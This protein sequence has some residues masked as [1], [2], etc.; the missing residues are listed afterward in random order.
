MLITITNRLIYVVY[1]LSI[2]KT[3]LRKGI[4]LFAKTN[5]TNKVYKPSNQDVQDETADPSSLESWKFSSSCGLAT[6]QL[7]S[8]IQTTQ[9]RPIG[10]K[11]S[12]IYAIQ[13]LFWS[14]NNL[15][16]FLRH[17]FTG[18]T[19]CGTRATWLVPLNYQITW[20]SSSMYLFFLHLLILIVFFRILFLILSEL[21][22]IF[23]SYFQIQLWSRRISKNQ[24]I[25]GIRRLNNNRKCVVAVCQVKIYVFAYSHIFLALS[26]N[27]IHIAVQDLTWVPCW[28]L[29]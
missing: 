8:K 4:S 21:K 17:P 16:D 29:L 11:L 12:V 27:K 3:T 14:T 18:P 9:S 15:I 23:I 28:A 2:F 22:R 6:L 5:Y 26:Q 20:R 7:R 19:T 1:T 25:S 10:K 13:S 24:V